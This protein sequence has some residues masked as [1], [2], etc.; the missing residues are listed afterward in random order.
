MTSRALDNLAALYAR[1]LATHIVGKEPADTGRFLILSLLHLEQDFQACAIR[2]GGLFMRV[3][4]L[5][6]C[7]TNGRDTV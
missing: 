2:P 5:T 1:L 4:L 7:L 6:V 3:R